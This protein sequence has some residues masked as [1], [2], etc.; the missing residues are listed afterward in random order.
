L[1][2]FGAP[3]GSRKNASSRKLSEIFEETRRPRQLTEQFFED[4][5]LKPAGTSFDPLFDFKNDSVFLAA[6]RVALRLGEDNKNDAPLIAAFKSAGLSPQNPLHWRALLSMFAEVHFAKTKTKTQRW[7][8]EGLFK[9]FIDY[10]TIKSENPGATETKIAEKLQKDKRFR[11]KYQRYN[12]AAF[13]KLI[14]QAKSPKTNVLLR[15]LEMMD[16]LLQLIRDDYEQRSIEW[17]PK[18]EAFTRG[19]VERFFDSL[20]AEGQT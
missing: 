18:L 9:L 17:T 2:E 15:H 20:A 14:R 16:A 1:V 12:D 7:G 19:I 3:M 10:I 11:E 5:L 8:P 13:R 6:S 4:D